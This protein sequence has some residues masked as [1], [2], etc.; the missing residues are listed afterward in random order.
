MIVPAMLTGFNKIGSLE[1]SRLRAK[2]WC[3]FLLSMCTCVLYVCFGPEEFCLLFGANGA[4]MLMCI[5]CKSH[6]GYQMR[7]RRLPTNRLNLEKC[8]SKENMNHDFDL[9]SSSVLLQQYF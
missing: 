5:L 6:E 3:V 7:Q 4:I 8:K 9:D 2:Q 1:R